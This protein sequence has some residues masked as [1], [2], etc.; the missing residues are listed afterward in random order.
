MAH[1]TA[2]DNKKKRVLLRSAVTDRAL[3]VGTT[4]RDHSKM[5]PK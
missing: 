1:C 5:D 3:P 2:A 4:G